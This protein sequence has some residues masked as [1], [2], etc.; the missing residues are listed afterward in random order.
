MSFIDPG[1]SFTQKLIG[2]TV[3]LANNPGTNQPST[4][5]E[6]SV[7]GQIAG[8]NTVTLSNSRTSV[9]IWNSGTFLQTATIKVWGLTPSL[10]NQLNT[11]GIVYNI[12]AKNTVTITAGDNINGMPA[13]FSGTIWSASGD[14]KS[15]PDVPF[16]LECNGILASAIA[17]VS[18]AGFKGWT[19]V[20]TI[21]SGMARQAGFGF[22]NFGVTGQLYNPHFRGT[23]NQQIDTCAR[24]SGTMYSTANNVLAIWPKGSSQ[25]AGLSIPIISPATG[26]IASPQ[27]TPQG[28]VVDT[29][30]NPL[31]G[32]GG[33]VQVQS[34]V[35]SGVLSA[36]SAANP[37]FNAPANGIWAVNKLDHALDSLVR[38]GQWK[39]TVYAWNP[40]Y[41]K[42]V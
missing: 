38:N 20:A 39:S 37:T 34:D 4:F 11:L 33:L 14:Y 29:L 40:N 36:Q 26:M 15:L 41:P 5:A 18:A 16:I 19:N 3:Q 35:L 27:L 6:G 30:F 31:I 7:P 2:I 12:V 1:A 24:H 8:G 22:Q 28:I 21:M 10:M 25:S 13:V 9:R 17:P 32:Y 23:T 42:P